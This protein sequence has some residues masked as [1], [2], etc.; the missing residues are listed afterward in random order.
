MIG[1][2][3]MG[4]T[5]VR[6]KLRTSASLQSRS[7]EPTGTH[8]VGYDRSQASYSCCLG[9]PFAQSAQ[10]RVK[11]A[12]IQVKRRIRYDR[13]LKRWKSRRAARVVRNRLAFLVAPGIHCRRASPW[14]KS[15]RLGSG[16]VQRDLA[17]IQPPAREQ[18]CSLQVWP[19]DGRVLRR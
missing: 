2:K 9:M 13:R 14:S 15:E 3:I 5:P 19:G 16:L 18:R 11:M 8:R 6:G 7:G 17:A 4:S 10:S 1:V 12:T